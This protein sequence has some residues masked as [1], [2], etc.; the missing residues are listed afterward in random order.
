MTAELAR[1]LTRGDA[2][3]VGVGPGDRL[4]V[5]LPSAPILSGVTVLAPGSTVVAVRWRLRQRR[6]H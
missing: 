2:V 4:V 5:T 1:R 3:V 6:G